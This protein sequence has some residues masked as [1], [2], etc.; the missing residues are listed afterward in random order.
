MKKFVSFMGIAA[1]LDRVNVDT[2]QI[3]PKQFL[4]KT[5]RNGFGKYLFF[6]WRYLNNGEDNKGFELNKP[7]FFN[8]S[9][10]VAGDN[11]G[12]GSSREHAPWALMDYGLKVI[13]ATGFADIFYNNCVKNGLLPAIVSKKD[14][15]KIK[16]CFSQ[17]NSIEIQ[18][19]LN[20]KKLILPEGSILNFM[21]EALSQ[22]ALLEGYDQ[23]IQTLRYQSE[24]ETFEENYKQKYP[25]CF[26][27]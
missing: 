26:S 5:D 2:D 21:I 10:L 19:D 14:F 4:T 27:V 3:I 6:D 15:E 24:L 22:K 9:I 17:E 18:V 13:I 25:W 20:S 16:S 11:F 23:I 12:C 7:E 1:L 8:A